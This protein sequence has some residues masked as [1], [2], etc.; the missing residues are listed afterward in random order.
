MTARAIIFAALLAAGSASAQAPAELSDAALLE[1]V[2]E[3][4][5]AGDAAELLAA[6]REVRARGLLMFEGPP[7]CEAPVPDTAFWDNEFFR[8]AAEKAFLVEA[9]EAAMA[10]GFCGCIW[11][12]RPFAAFFEEVTGRPPAELTEADYRTVRSYRRADWRSIEAS[13]AAFRAE[14]CGD[15]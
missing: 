4:T 1:R 5:E 14:R 8:G 3:V 10:A 2:A 7:R 6:M 11:E 12:A 15:D 13:Y 9:R